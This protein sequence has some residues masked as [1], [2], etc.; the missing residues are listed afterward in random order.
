M[1]WHKLFDRY[2]LTKRPTLRVVSPR[3]GTSVIPLEKND[4]RIFFQYLTNKIHSL[5]FRGSEKQL[6]SMIQK[7]QAEEGFTIEKMR[8]SPGR[9]KE[10]MVL[11]HLKFQDNLELRRIIKMG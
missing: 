3:V 7:M 10:K 2:S 4:S 5:H 11:L 9:R 1:R 6:V 8:T